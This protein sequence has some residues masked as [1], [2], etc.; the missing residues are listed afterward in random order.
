[1][2]ILRIVLIA[3]LIVSCQK[4]STKVEYR[5]PNFTTNST[6]AQVEKIIKEVALEKDF[7]VA[8]TSVPYEFAPSERIYKIFCL[9]G[10][11]WEKIEI[12]NGITELDTVYSN[13]EVAIIDKEVSLRLECRTDEADKFFNKLISYNLF[14]LAD[15]DQLKEKCME[16]RTDHKVPEYIDIGYMSFYIIQGTRVRRLDYQTYMREQ[17][18]PG[19]KEWQDIRNIQHVFKDEWY[20]KKH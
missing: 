14:T 7:T 11:T 19:M 5:I 10:N 2:R 13:T 20:V 12:R 9:K 1:M 17:D 18:C 3:W 4:R 6:L 8:Y 15:E 16:L